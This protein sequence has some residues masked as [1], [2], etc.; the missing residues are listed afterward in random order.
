[1]SDRDE[2]SVRPAH[3]WTDT[4]K[5]LVA[6]TTKV[7]GWGIAAGLLFAGWLMGGTDLEWKRKP[8]TCLLVLGIAAAIAIFWCRAVQVAVSACRA[9]FDQ[10]IAK[11]EQPADDPL[12]LI[13]H[14]PRL[15]KWSAVV[16]VL[17]TAGSFL[18]DYFDRL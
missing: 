11:T 1:M 3:E 17:A 14:A 4:Q 8:G 6:T 7:A 5:H 18:D 13:R 9:A 16:I 2:T 15:A 10:P 12:I